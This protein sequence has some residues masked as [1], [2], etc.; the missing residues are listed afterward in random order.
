MLPS[1]KTQ[2]NGGEELRTPP[3]PPFKQDFGLAI[4]RFGVVCRSVGS[5]PFTPGGFRL[6]QENIGES[7][8]ESGCCLTTPPA[9]TC[10]VVPKVY[11]PPRDYASPFH[12][13]QHPDA[14]SPDYVVSVTLCGTTLSASIIHENLLG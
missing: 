3:Y 14:C 12:P 10:R 8:L 13:M 1:N 7:L 4:T 5:W 9:L 2:E 11:P 6:T